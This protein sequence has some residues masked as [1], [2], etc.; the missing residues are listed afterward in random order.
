MKP[1]LRRLL[2]PDVDDLVGYVPENPDDFGFLLQIMAG[3]QGLDGEESF[4]IV[5]CSP[6]WLSRLL[7]ERPV[8]GR[9][10]L[11]MA[12]YEY[13]SLEAFVIGFLEECEGENWREVAH[14]IGRF[15]K[16]EFEDYVE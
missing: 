3:P 2:S 1:A 6:R 13:D 5:V 8:F 9:N 16:W 12:A 10:H 15:A 14:A 7:E 4:D 11:F